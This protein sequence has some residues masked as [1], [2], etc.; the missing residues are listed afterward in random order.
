MSAGPDVSAAVEGYLQ[1]ARW[2]LQA[3]GAHVA[4]VA[5]RMEAG[6]YDS[7]TAAA[8][9]A[10]CARLAG[11]SWFLLVNETVDAAA[12]LSGGHREPHIV[13]SIEFSAPV[14]AEGTAAPKPWSLALA[15]P[16]VATLGG[17]TIPTSAVSFDPAELGPTDARFA[18][19]VDA[20]GHAGVAYVGTVAVVA[21]DGAVL[22]P[23]QV[24]V[25]VP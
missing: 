2:W 12:V 20:T 7:G 8:D 19:R 6:S 18:L 1:L 11:E 10:E 13:E 17:T 9:L 3:W 24:W 16:L 25:A 23:V 4:G 22:D 21:A 5:A 14:P 15:G